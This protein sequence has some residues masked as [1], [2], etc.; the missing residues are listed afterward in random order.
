MCILSF[1]YQ[2]ESWFMIYKKW[3]RNSLMSKKICQAGT[4]M[5]NTIPGTRY[6]IKC[7]CFQASLGKTQVGADLGLYHPR[8]LRASAPSGQLQTTSGHHHPAPAQL[9]L[10][11]GHRLVLSG[12]SQSLH[13]TSLGKSLPSICQQQPSLNYK[14]RV[15]SAHTMGT[16]WAPSLGDRESCATGP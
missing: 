15:Y 16:P 11:R 14:R 7:L 4:A 10:H 8:N 2:T 9:I 3:L 13:L 12:H 1:P 5:Q 6:S